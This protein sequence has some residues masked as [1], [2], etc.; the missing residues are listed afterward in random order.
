MGYD[1][2][3][4]SHATV[5]CDRLLAAVTPETA[6]QRVGGN[7]ELTTWSATTVATAFTYPLKVALARYYTGETTRHAVLFYY[8]QNQVVTA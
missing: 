8:G 2:Y 3:L 5:V 6:W 4:K 7:A 1:I